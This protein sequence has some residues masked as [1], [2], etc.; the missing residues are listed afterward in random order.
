MTIAVLRDMMTAV[1]QGKMT[2]W[3]RTR[4]KIEDHR[5]MTKRLHRQDMMTGGRLDRKTGAED[6]LDSMTCLRKV[7]KE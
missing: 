5:G 1:H 6:L 3:H 2:D 4:T 7:D